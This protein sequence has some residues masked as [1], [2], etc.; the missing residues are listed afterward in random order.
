MYYIY[1]YI[2]LLILVTLHIYIIYI[3]YTYVVYK[4]TFIHSSLIFYH[5]LAQTITWH[6]DDASLF[7]QLQAPKTCKTRN[8]RRCF[9][10]YILPIK[11][12]CWSFMRYEPTPLK[13]KLS[14]LPTWYLTWRLNFFE[15]TYEILISAFQPI[16]TA[17]RHQRFFNCDQGTIWFL[18]L[19]FRILR[20]QS[21]SQ[22]SKAYLAYFAKGNPQHR[23]SKILGFF[24]MILTT[25]APK[26]ISRSSMALGGS[27]TEGK[28]YIAPPQKVQLKFEQLKQR[29]CPVFWKVSVDFI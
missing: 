28:A 4:C 6:C 8:F 9:L 3:I 17:P 14:K 7:Q 21:F 10:V 2:Y 18:I 20:A 24:N 25:S 5:L 22:K 16:N 12:P 15:I 11:P 19:L 13:G 27:F 29:T 26:I 1:I 23:P